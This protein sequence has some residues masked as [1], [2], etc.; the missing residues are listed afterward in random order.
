MTITDALCAYWIYQGRGNLAL[1]IGLRIPRSS[2]APLSKR[3]ARR[4]SELR[5]V[6]LK[7]AVQTTAPR[8]RRTKKLS[9]HFRLPLRS[10]DLLVVDVRTD[11]DELKKEES[12]LMGE[13]V[14]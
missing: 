13:R 11:Q 2:P 4:P 1:K 14:A 10:F 7:G 9:C 3:R 12:Y 8:A 5:Q 6:I